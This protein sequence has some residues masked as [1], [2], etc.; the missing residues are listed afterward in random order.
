MRVKAK[1]LILCI[2]DE[3][4]GLQVRSAVLERAGYRVLTA[5]DGA[6]GLA[7]FEQHPVE[8]VVL[9]YFMPGMNGAEVAIKMRKRR[10]D[11]PILLL[12]AY[13]DLPAEVTRVVDFTLMKGDGPA[14]LM[15]KV[16]EMLDWR[17]SPEDAGA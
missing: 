6:S 3:A 8:A 11:V 5:E 10:D 9:D 14:A 2:D 4:V 1:S 7:L 13:I 15:E 16:R 17:R 12:S